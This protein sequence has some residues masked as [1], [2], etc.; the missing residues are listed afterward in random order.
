L[1]ERGQFHVEG[2]RLEQRVRDLWNGGTPTPEW[3]NLMRELQAFNDRGSLLSATASEN[4]IRDKLGKALANMTPRFEL[5][6]VGSLRPLRPWLAKAKPIVLSSSDLQL[7]SYAQTLIRGALERELPTKRSPDESY[8]E[9]ITM[10]DKGE[11]LVGTWQVM[12][13]GTYFHFWPRGANRTDAP[14]IWLRKNLK[15]TPTTPLT[16]R[17]ANDYQQARD[18]LFGQLSQRTAWEDFVATCQRLAD[19]LNQRGGGPVTLSLTNEIAFAKEILA[20]WE[21]IGPFLSQ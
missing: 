2:S 20:A 11:L 15:Q 16:V 12:G 9:G 5:Y 17:C 4:Q 6:R 14:Q 3:E 7:R 1:L 10:G 21:D 13:N 19:E 8:Q 18:K